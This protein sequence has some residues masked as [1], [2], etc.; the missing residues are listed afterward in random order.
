MP[1][2]ILLLTLTLSDGVVLAYKNKDAASFLN[3]TAQKLTS[4]DCCQVFSLADDRDYSL[5]AETDQ[6]I[7]QNHGHRFRMSSK[8]LLDRKDTRQD[9]KVDGKSSLLVTDFE[10]FT[11]TDKSSIREFCYPLFH[12]LAETR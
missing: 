10:E 11:Q 1:A 2:I 7:Q 4:T 5:E 6:A 8:W 12:Q 9:S 3:A